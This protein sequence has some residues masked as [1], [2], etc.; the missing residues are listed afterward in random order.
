MPKILV[1]TKRQ[2]TG[3]DLLDDRFGRLREIPL[4]LAE[5]GY[6]VQGLCLSYI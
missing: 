2:Y 6:K 5:K 4:A 1:I 3:K